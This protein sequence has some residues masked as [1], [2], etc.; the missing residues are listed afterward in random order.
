MWVSFA[1]PNDHPKLLSQN[2]KPDMS[3]TL[4]TDKKPT[5]NKKQNKKTTTNCVNLDSI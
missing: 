1:H 3:H 4:S 5:K 2:L